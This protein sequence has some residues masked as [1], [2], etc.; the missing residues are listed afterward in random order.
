MIFSVF[1]KSLAVILSDVFLPTVIRF[2]SCA[3]N[4]LQ[5]LEWWC[6]HVK[7]HFVCQAGLSRP[8]F[9]VFSHPGQLAIHCNT[10]GIPFPAAYSSDSGKI[11]SFPSSFGWNQTSL[12]SIFETMLP[13]AIVSLTAFISISFTYLEPMHINLATAQNMETRIEDS[14]KIITG[15]RSLLQHC[16]RPRYLESIW[17]LWTQ[18]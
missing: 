6:F 18:L 9:L 8:V 1:T 3:V 14:D 15:C 4:Y 12:P 10:D 16:G 17:V 5:F 13:E 11:Y 2:F 7:C